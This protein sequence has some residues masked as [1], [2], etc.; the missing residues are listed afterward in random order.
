MKIIQFD[1]EKYTSVEM[2][3]IAETLR[4]IYKDEEIVLIPKDIEIL[5]AEE[6]LDFL[7]QVKDKI[8]R[9]IEYI[10]HQKII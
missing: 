5:E 8:D 6:N 3:H 9:Q 2:R 1:S 4:D 7:Y 10:E